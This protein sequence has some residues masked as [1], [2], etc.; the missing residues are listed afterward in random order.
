[1]YSS[2]LLIVNKHISLRLMTYKKFG[3]PLGE[4]L[5]AVF[6]Y[7]TQKHTMGVEKYLENS[8]TT[9][10]VNSQLIC[11]L[12]SLF[13]SSRLMAEV[14][15]GPCGLLWLQMFYS[16]CLEKHR[17][18]RIFIR[19]QKYVAIKTIL[20]A[21]KSN[22]AQILNLWIWVPWQSTFSKMEANNKQKENKHPLTDLQPCMSI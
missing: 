19:K 17:L 4:V 9:A 5:A 12:P 13:T 21:I 6:E 2:H 20:S 8:E 14:Q 22:Q 18:L 11:G 16:K 15:C 7:K 10:C 3:L 1:M